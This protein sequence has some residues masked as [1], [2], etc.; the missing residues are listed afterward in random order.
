[1]R[2][3]K[4]LNVYEGRR[5]IRGKEKRGRDGGTEEGMEGEKEGGREKA[6]GHLGVTPSK[7]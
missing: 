1:M 6:L 3:E 7:V 5:E 2:K 4:K